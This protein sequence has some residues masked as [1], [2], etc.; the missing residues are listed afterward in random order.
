MFPCSLPA[1]GSWNTWFTFKALWP[2]PKHHSGFTSH[3]VHLD[4]WAHEALSCCSTS[5]DPLCSD[6]ICL[7][8]STWWNSAPLSPS[9]EHAY[10]LQEGHAGFP[11]LNKLPLLLPVTH[12]AVGLNVLLLCCS[13]GVVNFT[14][15]GAVLPE[16]FLD[17][18]SHT[19]SASHLGRLLWASLQLSW[20]TLLFPCWGVHWS[21]VTEWISCLAR[22][23]L[24]LPPVEALIMGKCRPR[25]PAQHPSGL[26]LL[27]DH[28]GILLR[29]GHWFSR[30]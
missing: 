12:L 6:G 8:F 18:P 14:G 13:S 23:T 24:P 30:L 3:D 7:P 4:I 9:T 10:G 5:L 22:W 19:P 16:I 1:C 25:I 2:S 11:S 26:I 28:V 29:C 15:A 27:A 21:G 17:G 20:S